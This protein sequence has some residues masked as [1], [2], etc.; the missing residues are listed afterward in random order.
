M[1]SGLERIKGFI[2]MIW[3]MGLLK[4]LIWITD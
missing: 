3:H 1:D 4:I 2:R